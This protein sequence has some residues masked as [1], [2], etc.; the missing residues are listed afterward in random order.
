MSSL[1]GAAPFQGTFAFTSTTPLGLRLWDSVT[2]SVIAD[3]MSVTAYPPA[4][5]TRRVEAFTNRQG[6]YILRNL[7]GLQAIEQGKGDPA[8]WAAHSAA[9]RFFIEV[10]DVTKE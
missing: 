6:V 7:P 5:P 1:Y 4:Q 2:S 8:F 10:V 3:G 9:R